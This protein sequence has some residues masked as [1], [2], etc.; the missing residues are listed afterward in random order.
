[1]LSLHI[2]TRK[3]N[4]CKKRKPERS[5][6]G[7][8]LSFDILCEAVELRRRIIE[9]VNDSVSDSE[10]SRDTHRS[11]TI[12]GI[13]QVKLQRAYGGCLGTDSR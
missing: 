12:N 6:N 2:V 10:H 1:M 4:Q 9:A 5:K 8:T 13:R 11:K 3:D 7:K